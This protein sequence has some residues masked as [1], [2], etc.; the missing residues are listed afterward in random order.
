MRARVEAVSL[1]C[2]L[3]D[4]TSFER[5]VRGY[6][7]GEDGTLGC[8]VVGSFAAVGADG[9]RRPVYADVAIANS[10]L[11]F[12]DD[13]TQEFFLERAEP[14]VWIAGRRCTVTVEGAGCCRAE[15]F[16]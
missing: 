5:A 11:P 13:D 10:A 2:V 14:V 7:T 12:E 16:D 3:P 1:S 8:R 6:F 4:G 9:R 15:G